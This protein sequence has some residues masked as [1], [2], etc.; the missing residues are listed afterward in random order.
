MIAVAP[1][2]P[3]PSIVSSHRSAACDRCALTDADAGQRAPAG[4]LT[5]KVITEPALG[6]LHHVYKQQHDRPILC[7]LHLPD[8]RSS[9]VGY[10]ETKAKRYNL[11]GHALVTPDSW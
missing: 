3:M 5:Y 9:V 1:M 10:Q 4:P 7:A 11:R 6:G 8:R 2:T